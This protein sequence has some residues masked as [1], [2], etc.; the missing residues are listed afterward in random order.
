MECVGWAA[1]QHMELSSLYNADDGFPTTAP[2]GSFPS[3][4]SRFG[5]HDVVGNVWE[6]VADWY[7]EYASAELANP[8]GP[9]SG[10]KRVIR[11]GGWD[12]SH[13]TW[14][15]PSFR[16]GQAPNAKSPTIGF[17]CAKSL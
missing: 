16:F 14:L 17:R 1:K 11:G 8:V 10:E 13:T 3:G 15:R 2:V 6:W 4:S 5:P 12:G 9:A 7:G